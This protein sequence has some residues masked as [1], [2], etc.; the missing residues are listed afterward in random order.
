MTASRTGERV[1]EPASGVRGT[2][3]KKI[4]R[5][6]RGWRRELAAAAAVGAFLGL[7]GPFGSYSSA[8]MA[9]RIAYWT[10]SAVVGTIVFGTAVRIL[11][12]H[13][14]RG[15]AV[16]SVIPVAA[17]LSLPFA[18]LVA[19]PAQALWPHTARI[20][21]LHWYLQVFAISAPLCVAWVLLA[22]RADTFALAP[23]K[24]RPEP[25]RLG[26]EASAVLCLQMED[27][28]VRVHHVN[29]SALVLTT[30][31]Q[32]QEALQGA[33]GLQV[34]RSWWVAEKAVAETLVEG[35][36]LRLR[37]TNGLLVPVSRAAV[38]PVRAAG[39]LERHW[40]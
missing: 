22:R 25:S 23:P 35:R 6:P 12:A 27:H 18:L 21:M 30:M 29:G 1:R 4:G 14:S 28:Y 26:V 40:S 5:R 7:V 11:A 3:W 17:I 33:V 39:W 34:H 16:A 15:R 37:L 32:A 19:L 9:E 8:P 38:A 2:D 20:P 31:R 13:G 10:A 24:L 36:N